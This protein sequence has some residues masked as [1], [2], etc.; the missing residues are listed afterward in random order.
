MTFGTIV[1]ITLI[2]ALFAVLPT[3]PHSSHWGYY[4]TALVG[5]LLLIA[6]FL[7]EMGGI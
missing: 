7:V 2:I 1:L 6:A 5:M 4:P 3:W